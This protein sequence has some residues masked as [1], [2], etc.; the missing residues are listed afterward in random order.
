MEE[1][2]RL[3]KG[4]FLKQKNNFTWPVVL[5]TPLLGALLSFAN[6]YLRYD[7]L[8]SLKAQ[9]GITSWQVL[10]TQHHFIWAFL[11]PLVATVLASQVHYLE[12]KSN[13]WKQTL[14]LPVS[15][16]KVYLAKWSVVFFLNTLMILGNSIYLI[17]VGKVL[18]FPEMLDVSLFAD[19]TT[20]Q[21]LAITGLI[22]F[23]CWL[24]AGLSNANL[25]LAIGFVGI[26]SSLF[27]AQSE[28]LAKFI[29][30]AHIIYTLPDPTINN[31]IAI[32][33]GLTF[34]LI[35]L[36]IGIM[37]FNRKEIY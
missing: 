10:I 15:R 17:I 25:A 14:A 36:G 30:Y 37:Y 5:L 26:A 4:E 12:Y 11:L 13:S 22:G 24:S 6:L 2:Y 27:F 28:Q 35:F 34:G 32:Y 9:Q 33:Y 7:Y 21:I 23:Q 31:S 19:Y 20:Y 8:I 16:V 29:P 3:L 18:A 1:Y